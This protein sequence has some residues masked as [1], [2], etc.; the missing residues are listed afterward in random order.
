MPFE[1]GHNLGKGRPKGS[2]NKIDG[3]IKQFLKDL[4]E[5]NQEKV[6]N[7]LDKLEGKA[8]LDAVLSIMEYVQPKL[9][10]AEVVAEIEIKDEVD[11]SKYSVDDLK[12]SIGE[13]D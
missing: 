9:S 11:L 2:P 4:V 12:D 3:T 13:G 8:Y 1:K 10:R 6:L 5:D 7:Q